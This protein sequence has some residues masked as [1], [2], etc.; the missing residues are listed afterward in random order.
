LNRGF[1]HGLNTDETQPWPTAGIKT[2]GTTKDP[3]RPPAAT[4]EIEQE[5][6]EETEKQ[7]DAGNSVLSAFSC[8]NFLFFI[9]GN[10]QEGKK[11]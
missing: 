6:T 2:R 7:T 9:R 10:E 11:I 8:S 3:A 1:S 5:T 4:K